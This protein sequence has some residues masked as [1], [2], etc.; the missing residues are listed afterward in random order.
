[1][2]YNK[3]SKMDSIPLL[4][5]GSNLPEGI[6]VKTTTNKYDLSC[7]TCTKAES[8]QKNCRECWG[9]IAD[10]WISWD[11][12]RASFLE[13]AEWNIS[14]DI[15]NVTHKG[16]DGRD[17]GRGKSPSEVGSRISESRSI[18]KQPGSPDLCKHNAARLSNNTHPH[19][20]RTKTPP[21]GILSPCLF[22]FLTQNL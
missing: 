12:F 14:S 5:K 4:P 16:K 11:I 19:A 15:N 22:L 1:M 21:N 2:W 17:E 3:I 7:T 20:N 13:E 9:L 10:V 8:V 6:T 18:Q